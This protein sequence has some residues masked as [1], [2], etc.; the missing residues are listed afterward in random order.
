MRSVHGLYTISQAL[1]V[2]HYMPFSCALT[3]MLL[4]ISGIPVWAIHIIMVSLKCKLSLNFCCC[5][6]IAFIPRL[7]SLL[8]SV[9]VCSVRINAQCQQIILFALTSNVMKGEFSDNFGP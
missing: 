8:M 1:G 5:G 3:C 6:W 7:L 4:N 9:L 2:F